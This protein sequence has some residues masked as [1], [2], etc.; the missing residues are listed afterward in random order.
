MVSLGYLAAAQQPVDCHCALNCNNCAGGIVKISLQYRGVD[1]LVTVKDP[2]QIYSSNVRDGQIIVLSGS[3]PNG[4][5]SGTELTLEINGQLN[6]TIDVTCA[7]L[8]KVNMVFGKFT[9]TSAESMTGGRVCCEKPQLDKIAPVFVSDLT[10][11]TA[12]A[13]SGCEAV[14]TWNEP[15]V[16]DC[17]LKTID[18]NFV[19]GTVF[20]LGETTV[21]YTA[22]DIAANKTNFSFVVKV[23][24]GN[25]PVIHNC[26]T[27]ISLQSTNGEPLAVEWEEVTATDNCQV[28]SLVSSHN[29]GAL[30][31]V[32]ETSVT[33]TAID[34]A[35]NSNT[36]T[37]KVS[38]AIFDEEDPDI[39]KFL[40][41]V[42]IITPDGDGNNDYWKITNIGLFERN[43]VQV[44][45][46][47]GS[48]IFSATNYDNEVTV[49]RG[50]SRDSR[51][52]PTGT[53]FYTI[54]L[55][56]AGKRFEN[57]GFLEVI[58]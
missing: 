37:F 53:Y 38:V 15:E 33:Y 55:W 32:G 12:Y 13:I 17:N 20:P 6:A 36:C 25:A 56:K 47:W 29:S 45:D 57:R 24:D 10:T 35:G 22:V 3:L 49:W 18:S 28:V 5:F 39:E 40:D 8:V 50:T 7:A 58:N 52:V 46:R 34:G 43:Q 9:V 54:T 1:A 42:R 11:V 31:S 16:I 44:V 30:Y 2:R 21:Q 19:P 27:R 23:L 48:E 41:I 51:T 26:P 4:K 14:V